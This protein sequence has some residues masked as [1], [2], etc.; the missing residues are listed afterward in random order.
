MAFEF[1]ITDMTLTTRRS[2]RKGAAVRNGGQNIWFVS[3][4]SHSELEVLLDGGVLLLGSGRA[5]GKPTTGVS[6]SLEP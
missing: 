3:M 1:A 4:G 5:L 6:S 2:D